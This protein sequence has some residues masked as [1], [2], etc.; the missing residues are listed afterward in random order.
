[1]LYEKAGLLCNL[2]INI[3]GTYQLEEVA[4]GPQTCSSIGH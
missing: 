2:G 3:V 1:M 4:H